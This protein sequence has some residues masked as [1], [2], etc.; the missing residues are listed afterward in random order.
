M[1]FCAN[2]GTQVEGQFC[3]TCGRPVGAS[4]AQ[5]QFTPA[6]AT[7]AAAGM[8]DNVAGLLCY[9]LGFV[10]GIIFLVLAPYNQNKFIRFHAYQS[11]FLS[12]AWVAVV[13]VERIVSA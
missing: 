5:P 8:T 12:V 11:I 2:C 10:T 13:I 4:P 6:A 7:P 1:A 9:I 3:A